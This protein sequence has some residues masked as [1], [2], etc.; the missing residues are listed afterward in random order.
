MNKNI[1]L[2]YKETT[3]FGIKREAGNLTYFQQF[4]CVRYAK[5]RDFHEMNCFKPLVFYKTHF[6]L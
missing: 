5:A 3:H 6:T 1:F 2:Y 4:I